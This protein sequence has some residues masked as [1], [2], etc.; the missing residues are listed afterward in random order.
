[1]KRTM[2]LVIVIAMAVSARAGDAE[3]R[4][5]AE[6]LLNAMDM[7]A[8]IE[9]SF[10]MVK[11]MIPQQMASLGGATD[12]N[13]ADVQGQTETILNVVM[14]AMNW[15]ALKEDYIA[16]YA[17]TFTEVELQGVV[18]FYTSAAGRRFLEKQPE[19]M[20]RSMEISQRQMLALI[21]KIQAMTLG[22][23]KSPPMAPPLAP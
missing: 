10:A 1:M 7:Q 4:A 18:D 5:L 19:L 2:T 22:D 20:R 17:E 23:G 15:D 3:R 21:P 12:L 13:T 14:E 9:R 6:E 16:I 8:N 11:D